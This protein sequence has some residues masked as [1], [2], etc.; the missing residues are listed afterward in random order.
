MMNEMKFS[1]AGDCGNNGEG[2][3][4]GEPITDPN[5]VFQYLST[6]LMKEKQQVVR[7]T[8]DTATT[9]QQHQHPEDLTALRLSWV[10]TVVRISILFYFISFYF[11]I[12]TIISY[13]NTVI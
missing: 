12:N 2:A 4:R 7:S 11:Q 6:F 9:S 1:C 10:S 5:I 13:K 3:S 8:G